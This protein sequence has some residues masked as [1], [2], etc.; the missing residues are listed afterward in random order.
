MKSLQYSRKSTEKLVV[1]GKVSPDYIH[2]DYIEDDGTP[3][4]IAVKDVLKNFAGQD[5]SV[6]VAANTDEDLL[7]EGKLP[8]VEDEEDDE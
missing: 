1:K 8:E 2:I 4:S 6:T 5:V 3:R 7:D